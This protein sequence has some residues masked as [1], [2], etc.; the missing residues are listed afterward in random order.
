MVSAYE[1]W[2]RHYHFQSFCIGISGSVLYDRRIQEFWERYRPIAIRRWRIDHGEVELSAALR[3]V[4]PH[5]KV[6]YGLND[7]LDVLTAERR[8]GRHPEISGVRTPT[9]ASPFSSGRGSCR[10]YSRPSRASANS[11]FDG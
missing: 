9:I 8:L 10:C 7:L 1:C 2:E 3:K 11:C 4:S 5:F 6:V